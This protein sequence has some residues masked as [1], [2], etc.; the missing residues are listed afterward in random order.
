[1]GQTKE[2]KERTGKKGKKMGKRKRRRGAFLLKKNERAKQS[3]QNKTASKMKSACWSFDFTR[4]LLQ[5]R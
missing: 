1:L 4:S 3:K 5:R 2:E